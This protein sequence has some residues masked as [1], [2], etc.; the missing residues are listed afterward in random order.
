MK[1]ELISRNEK[2]GI[3]FSF[4]FWSNVDHWEDQI[5]YRQRG[6]VN[7]T[8]TGGDSWLFQQGGK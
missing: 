2:Q 6:I 7:E 1:G 4:S 8:M 3:T 5:T